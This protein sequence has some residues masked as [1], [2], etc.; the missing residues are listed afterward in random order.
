MRLFDHKSEKVLHGV[1]VFL[2]KDEAEELR[3]SVIGLLKQPEYAAH[4]HIYCKDYKKELIV[5]IYNEEDLTGFDERS[6]RLISL[7]E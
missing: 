4:D 7:D 6:K 1:T 3:D 5:C 2:T